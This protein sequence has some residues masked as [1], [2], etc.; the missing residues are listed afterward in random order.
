[1]LT[2]NTNWEVTQIAFPRFRNYSKRDNIYRHGEISEGFYLVKQGSV[3]LQKTLPNGAQSI[4]KIVTIGDIFGEGESNESQAKQNNSFAIAL[5]DGTMIQKISN[6]N[7]QESTNG[8][9]LHHKLLNYNLEITKR[10]ERLNWMDA[11]CRI[12]FTLRE[13]A[14]KLG[15]R[16]GDET[17][18]KLNLTHEELAM[19]T[20]SSRQTVTKTLSTLKRKGII[21]YSRNRILFR[22]L[23]TFN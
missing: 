9:E 4:L 18:L 15:K 14:Q 23:E 11:E 6:R 10:L 17:L 12:K 3:K 21:T 22:N 13:L 5:E 20:D 16:F 8:I 2:L 19:L 1:M 7:F